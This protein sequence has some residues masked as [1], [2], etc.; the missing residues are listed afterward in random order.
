M[1]R[2]VEIR[3]FK[4]FEEQVFDLPS[5]LVVVGPNN[6]GK[7]SLLQ[8]IATWS[9][10]ASHW[11]ETNPDFMRRDDGNYA[12]A[13][14]NMLRFDAVPVEGES[15]INNLREWAKVAGHPVFGFL[16][17][18]FWEATASHPKGGYAAS[19]FSALRQM[20]PD[21]R[22]VELRDGDQD[23]PKRGPTGLLR[24]R[25]RQTEIENYLLYPVA[26]ERFVQRERGRDVAEHVQKYMK[27][28][29][30]PVLFET[31]SDAGDIV[32]ATKGSHVLSRILQEAGLPPKK[33]EYS[34]IAAQMLPEEVHPE[35]REK[36]DAIADHFGIE[37]AS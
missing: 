34:R 15:D 30:P 13:D 17:K 3:D 28:I 16:N 4:L 19:H 14:L 20:V 29:L 11:F 18:P 32:A 37:P 7:T 8:A 25:W 36:L 22:G 27:R 12:S 9:E 31:P 6:C 26:L 10:I 1:L 23:V 24:L 35:V 2:R 33:T 5:H 21:V